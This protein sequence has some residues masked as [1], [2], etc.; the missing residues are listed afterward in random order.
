MDI[1]LTLQDSGGA[2]TT[3]TVPNLA[4]S[5]ALVSN[6]DID[7]SN[8]VRN[9]LTINNRPLTSNIV[10]TK[11]DLEL[12]NVVNLDTSTTANITDSTNKRFVTDAQR[13]VLSNTSGTNT[14][15]QDLSTYSQ[16][17]FKTISVSGQSNVVADNKDDTLTLVAGSN[18][19]LTTNA[20]N[21]S[22]T[23]DAT[24]GGGT[25]GHYDIVMKT[26]NY[27]GALSASTTYYTIAEKV[28]M[29]PNS[30]IQITD[31]LYLGQGDTIRGL[32]SAV[33][34]VTVSVRV[35]EDFSP[36]QF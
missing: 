21:D 25:G 33:S 20:T 36:T 29:L 30:I 15:D 34:S 17:S 6:A 3:Y 7:L 18:I 13:T 22:I 32:A 4:K 8:F 31:I 1:S 10:L 5:I 28:P 23:I 27:S 12:S 14:G 11:N 26:S 24:G 16:F 35:E 9:T 19:T 2:P